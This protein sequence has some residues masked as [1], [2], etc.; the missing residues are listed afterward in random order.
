MGLTTMLG[1]RTLTLRGPSFPQ[2]VK[3]PPGVLD[4]RRGSSLQKMKVSASVAKHAH[5]SCFV[6]H[7]KLCSFYARAC[8]ML[9]QTI[10]EKVAA[11]PVCAACYSHGALP[12]AMVLAPQSPKSAVLATIAHL[13]ALHDRTTCNLCTACTG[14]TARTSIL[15]QLYGWCC[16]VAEKAQLKDLQQ[17][18]DAAWKKRLTTKHFA[19]V[20]ADKEK[21]SLEKLRP[22]E[23]VSGCGRH[24]PFFSWCCTTCKYLAMLIAPPELNDACLPCSLYSFCN[25]AAGTLSLRLYGT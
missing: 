3:A 1:W 16:A 2:W 23:Y 21:A 19:N 4:Q 10:L 6:L 13:H 25:L 18:V 12:Y 20:S 15:R 5:Q 17:K 22:A 8:S 9:K 24:A 14:N 11:V 7:G